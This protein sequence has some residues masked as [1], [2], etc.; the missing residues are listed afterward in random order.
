MSQT[1]EQ[2]TYCTSNIL[3]TWELRLRVFDGHPKPQLHLLMVSSYCQLHPS[4]TGQFKNAWS[5]TSPPYEIRAIRFCPFF[6]AKGKA[7]LRQG[8]LVSFMET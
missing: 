6:L 5:D 4:Y 8:P 2:R 1:L 3:V 7:S